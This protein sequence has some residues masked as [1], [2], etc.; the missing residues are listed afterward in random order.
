VEQLLVE[1]T[2]RARREAEETMRLVRD[3]M[4]LYRPIG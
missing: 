3:A 1:G 4:G 2:R